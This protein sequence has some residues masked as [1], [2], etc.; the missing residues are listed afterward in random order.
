MA[1]FA[2]LVGW[3]LLGLLLSHD[4]HHAPEPFGLIELG[5]RLDEAR[6]GLIGSRGYRGAGG[7]THVLPPSGFWTQTYS[8]G[9]D[10]HIMIEWNADDRI[11]NKSWWPAHGPHWTE[12]ARA[13]FDRVRAIVRF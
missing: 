6:A 9:D 2:A 5:M 12:V 7:A 8:Y 1:G 3:T 4:F 11:T 10:G 13:W